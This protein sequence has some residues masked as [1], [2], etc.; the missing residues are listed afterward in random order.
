MRQSDLDN[1]LKEGMNWTRD[2]DKTYNMEKVCALLG[3]SDERSKAYIGNI[4]SSTNLLVWL[5]MSFSFV[6][7]FFTK[8]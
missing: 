3:M 6:Y 1:L 7:L 4:P 5:F 8:F 2:G